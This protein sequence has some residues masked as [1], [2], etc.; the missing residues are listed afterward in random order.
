MTGRALLTRAA[1]AGCFV[2]KPRSI[3][4]LVLLAA[5]TANGWQRSNENTERDPGLQ[6]SGMAVLASSQP[7]ADFSC[8]VTADKPSLL[9]LA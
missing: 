6:D 1:C 8:Q 5:S 4:L 3:V 9:N 7:R 2:A